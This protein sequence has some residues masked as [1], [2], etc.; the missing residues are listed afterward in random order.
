MS[1][2]YWVDPAEKHRAQRAA[3]QA[4]EAKAKA[5]AER[6]AEE[7]W[8]DYVTRTKRELIFKPSPAWAILQPKLPE[9]TA[10]NA[11]NIEAQCR[12]A[13]TTFHEACDES[14]T[15]HDRT[16]LMEFLQC[17]KDVLT[18]DGMGAVN[19]CDPQVY[20]DAWAYISGLLTKPEPKPVAPVATPA[21]KKE[22]V[23]PCKF[24]A[25]KDSPYQRAARQHDEWVNPCKYGTDEYMRA[26][27]QHYSELAAQEVA[28]TLDW[29]QI[30]QSADNMPLN[31]TA[32]AALLTELGKTNKPVNM[33][34]A[35][36]LAVRMWPRE[37]ILTQEE[38]EH[39]DMDSC[40]TSSELLKKFPALG[41]PNMRDG[42]R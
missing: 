12:N 13:W 7:E 21:K 15:K 6:E 40:A 28:A 37:I 42:G 5:A 25:D 19:L 8:Q 11:N 27:R 4:Q 2:R 18:R 26:D 36:A 1:N 38:Q 9:I 30:R 23:N 3:E 24:S 35:R 32:R 17:Q 22:W 10:K 33:A 41:N 16:L 39:L 20:F 29:S 14:F 31:P 34:N